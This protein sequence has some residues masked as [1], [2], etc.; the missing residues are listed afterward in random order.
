MRDNGRRPMK[1]R[2]LMTA[3][4]ATM[5]FVTP[6]WAWHR[7]DSQ[8]TAV[9]DKVKT[10]KPSKYNINLNVAGGFGGDGT[11]TSVGCVAGDNFAEVCYSGDCT[12]YTYTGTVSGA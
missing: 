9:P 2:F 6:S 5:F 4:L 7:P 8:Q 1:F 3:I 10:P 11:A 12:C